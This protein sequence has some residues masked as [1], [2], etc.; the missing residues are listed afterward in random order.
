MNV[1]NKKNIEIDS[2]PG[3]GLRRVI[4]K[5]SYYESDKMMVGYAMYCADYGEMQPHAHD[6]ETVIITKVNNGYVSWGKDKNNMQET[7]GLKEGMI[8][9]IPENEWH[10]FHYDENGSIEIIFIYGKSDNCRP[11]DKE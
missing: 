4:G 8:L 3:R 5:N 10:V 7:L 1:V 2:L 9:H 11:E 6:E